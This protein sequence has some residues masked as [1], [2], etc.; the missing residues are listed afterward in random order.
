ML[1]L[2]YHGCAE[3]LKEAALLP[4]EMLSVGALLQG[5]LVFW[6]GAHL[7]SWLFHV[8]SALLKS[9]FLQKFSRADVV[10]SEEQTS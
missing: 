9:L 3:T 7:H 4:E 6:E 2:Q 5:M 10:A 1:L 8:L